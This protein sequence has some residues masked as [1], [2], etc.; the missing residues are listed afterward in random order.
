MKKLKVTQQ[1]MNI[2]LMAVEHGFRE[3]ERGKNLEGALAS[4]F[5]LYEVDAGRHPNPM[6]DAAERAALGLP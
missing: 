6:I 1:Q 4:V 5:D 3:G 2:I